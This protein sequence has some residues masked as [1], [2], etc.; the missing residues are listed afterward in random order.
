MLA[1]KGWLELHPTK[2]TAITSE[3]KIVKA[4]ILRH[5]T[6]RNA[7]TFFTHDLSE[8]GLALTE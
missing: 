3:Q 7:E 5:I 4:M 8:F 1:R 2:P 6:N